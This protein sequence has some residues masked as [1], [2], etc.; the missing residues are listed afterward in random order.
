MAP[1]TRSQH[2]ALGKPAHRLYH[3][4]EL[5]NHDSPPRQTHANPATLAAFAPIPWP[6]HLGTLFAHG[7]IAPVFLQNFSWQDYPTL[8]AVARVIN[9]TPRWPK[10]TPQQPRSRMVWNILRYFTPPT[11]N[12]PR[13]EKLKVQ[14]DHGPAVPIHLRYE[15]VVPEGPEFPCTNVVHGPSRPGEL[16]MFDCDGVSHILDPTHNHR[17]F[18]LRH[19]RWICTDCAEYEYERENINFWDP[20]RVVPFCRPCSLDTYRRHHER[21]ECNCQ[22]YFAPENNHHFCGV[23][24]LLFTNH[25]RDEMVANAQDLLQQRPMAVHPAPMPPTIDVYVGEGQNYQN[26]RNFCPRNYGRDWYQIV[27]SW[28]FTT[29]GYR[30]RYQRRICLVC[31]GTVSKLTS[32]VFTESI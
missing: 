15:W 14:V 9:I 32:R 12:T 7:N 31:K 28:T 21:R 24:R 4:T 11:C 5:P 29:R 19:I 6:A 23:C 20:E 16:D 22:K 25:R 3:H 8:R 17:V 18:P 30:R 2:N 1:Y 26:F 10:W 27:G 13:V